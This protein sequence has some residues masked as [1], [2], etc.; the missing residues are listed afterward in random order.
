MQREQSGDCI[1]KFPGSNL[2]VYILTLKLTSKL[3][4]FKWFYELE[5]I[6]YLLCGGE[7]ECSCIKRESSK[8]NL[9]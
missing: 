8:I 3:G 5:G 6:A 7:V 1:R 2:L 9:I 4:K